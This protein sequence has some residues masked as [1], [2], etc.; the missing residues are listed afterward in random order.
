VDGD[1]IG[2]DTPVVPAL[3][4]AAADGETSIDAAEGERTGGLATGDAFGHIVSRGVTIVVVDTLGR[5]D[6]ATGDG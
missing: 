4:A 2:M 3:P 6:D 5:I 1:E